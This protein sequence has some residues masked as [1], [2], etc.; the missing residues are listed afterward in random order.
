MTQLQTYEVGG[1]RSARPFRIRRLGHIA[2]DIGHTASTLDFFVRDL[3]LYISD[4]AD[5]RGVP[6]LKEI[7]GALE[8]PRAF[9]LSVASDH[10]S[11]VLLPREVAVARRSPDTPADITNGQISFQVN[12]LQEVVAA[13]AFLESQ[14]VTVPRIGR[15]LPGSNWH[16]YFPG[17]DGVTVELYYGM[18]QIGWQRRSKSKAM[19]ALA[20]QGVPDMP[21]RAEQAEV[22]EF[23]AQDID[24]NGGYR[25]AFAEGDGDI[26]DGAALPRPFRATR[27]GPASFFVDDVERSVAFYSGLLG[28][29]VTEWAECFGRRCAFLR[30]GSEHHSLAL[31]PEPL[32][33]EL[34]LGRQ[35]R[36]CAL[37]LQLGSYDQLRRAGLFMIQRG[38][39]QT[40][41]LPPELHTGIDRALYFEDP[42]GNRIMLYYYMEQIGWDGRPRPAALRTTPDPR[43]VAEWAERIEGPSDVYTDSPLLGPL[44]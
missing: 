31:L 35:S 22:E 26:V 30:A 5:L 43:P 23:L 34:G 19:Y 4:P 13:K 17:P 20:S 25:P 7:A 27:I 37:G 12:S 44:G 6:G 21:I 18:E 11:I 39:K 36:H 2:F 41:G 3:G 15:D 14:G 24:I 16:T 40:Q 38:W 1:V 42:R 10:H 29:E 8:D 33:D 28:L 9:F 32:R